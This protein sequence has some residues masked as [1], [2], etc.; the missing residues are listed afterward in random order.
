M[1]FAYL[2]F[3]N[4]RFVSPL[5]CP[6]IRGKIALAKKKT[7]KST[8]I[9]AAGPSGKPADYRIEFR[10]ADTLVPYARNARRHSPEQVALIMGLIREYGFTN[11]ILADDVIRAGHG[12]R[13]AAL[14]LYEKG[15]TIRLPNGQPLPKGSVPV[16]DCSGW[17]E[18]QKQAY[19]LADNQSAL[20]ADWDLQLLKVELDDLKAKDVELSGLGFDDKALAELFAEKGAADADSS[21]Q[22]GDMTFQIVVVCRDEAHQRELLEKFETE[23]LTCRALIS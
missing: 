4:L 12:R 5:K 14:Q 7:A 13:L 22:L 16:I 10:R 9:A 1:A 8:R 17:S 11:P 2:G 18:A 20:A 19:V 6:E 3:R 21:P 15:E 23:G